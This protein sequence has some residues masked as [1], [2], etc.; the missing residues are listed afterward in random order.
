MGHRRF[1]P[2][3]RV[4]IRPQPRGSSPELD[5]RVGTVVKAHETESGVRY[6]AVLLDP[7]TADDSRREVYISPAELQLID[8]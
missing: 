7:Q 8:P 3:S 6:L 4:C 1:K 2:G 5:G